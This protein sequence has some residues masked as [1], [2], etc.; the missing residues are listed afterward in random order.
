MKVY[1]KNI[2]TLVTWSDGLAHVSWLRQERPDHTRLCLVWSCRSWHRHS[3]W[4]DPSDQVT[5]VTMCIYHIPTK[6]PLDTTYFRTQ[7]YKTPYHATNVIFSLS[8]SYLFY[9]PRK[10][11]APDGGFWILSAIWV[12]TFVIIK[13][14]TLFNVSAKRLDQRNKIKQDKYVFLLC[15]N[16]FTDCDVDK[17]FARHCLAPRRNVASHG[18]N[19]TISWAYR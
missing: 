17:V 7:K 14:A 8:P 13:I 5:K 1:N 2:I 10:N 16:K 12:I 11:P 18:I 6:I 9:P 3:T 4:S 19:F 15:R